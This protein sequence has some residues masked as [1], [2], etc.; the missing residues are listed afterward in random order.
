ML[1]FP[2]GFRIHL[3]LEAV[4]MRKSF[5]LNSTVGRDRKALK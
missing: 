3:A 5:N 4:D 2:V 1:A